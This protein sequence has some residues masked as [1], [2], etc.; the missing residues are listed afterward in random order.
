MSQ[1]TETA[2]DAP[3]VTADDKLAVTTGKKQNKK[4]EEV[5]E[6]EEEEYVV[7]KVLDRRV[8]KGRVEYLLRWKGFTDN[9]NTWEPED[10]LDCPDL[11][12]EYLQ[13]H[14]TPTDDKKD[15]SGKRKG[16]S[17]TDGTEEVRSKKR[18]DEQDKPRGFARGLEPE[19]IIGATDSSGELMFLMKWRNSDEADLVP[20]KE[21]NVKCPQVVITFYEERLTWHSYPSEEEEKKDDK[22]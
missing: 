17:D 12:A 1:P 13:S 16:E 7:E 9:D 20:A 10:N 4:V 22:N 18:K 15:S 2:S 8:V 14:K 3:S 6:E 11:I 21:A 5:V 19:R